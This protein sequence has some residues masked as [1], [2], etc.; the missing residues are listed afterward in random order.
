MNAYVKLYCKKSKVNSTG[1]APIYFVIKLNGKEK[2]LSTG[3]SIAPEL[4]D[5][6]GGG[7]IINK[8]THGKLNAYLENKKSKINGI[9]LDLQYQEASLSFERIIGKYQ[10]KTNHNCFI[11]FYQNELESLKCGI[12]YKTYKD[13]KVSLSNLKE[14]SNSLLFEEL[15][16]KFLVR[17]DTW[18][19]SVKGRNQNSRY[20]N[21]TALRKFLNLAIKYGYTQNYPFKDFKFSQRK[22]E[23]E[24]LSESELCKLQEL[25]DS[26]TLKDKFQNTL[27][28]FLFTCYTGI[29]ADDM[30]HKER[31]SFNGT[32][33]AF[34]RGKTK[35]PVKIPLTSKALNL[36]PEIQS[37]ALKQS[38]HRVHKDLKCIMENAGIDKIVT[39]HVGRHTFA[40]IS[41][42]KG[43]SLS[44][45][46]KV[47]GHT[48]TKT[49]EIYAQVVDELMNK[50]MLKWDE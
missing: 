3:K 20:H 37:R 7:G 6:S 26:G 45:I 15:D 25:F 19:Q 2:L 4:F 9:I 41:L 33:V 47:L 28:N 49:T 17:Y 14:Y 48:S 16:Y 39:Y 42:M 18:L 32:T 24:Y 34:V 46:S 23:R 36:V 31:L 21:F 13:Y 40:I 22:V 38:S 27:A 29:A 35:V 8:S 11:D 12:A 5:N 43:I 50:E 1:Q 10:R 44:V 30:R